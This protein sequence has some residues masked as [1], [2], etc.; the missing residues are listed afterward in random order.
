MMGSF[1]SYFFT[2]WERR[3]VGEERCGRVYLN[4]LQQCHN[5]VVEEGSGRQV[6][7]QK[8]ILTFSFLGESQKRID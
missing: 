6:Q 5:T 4:R 8:E 1:K 3:G 2:V 7:N